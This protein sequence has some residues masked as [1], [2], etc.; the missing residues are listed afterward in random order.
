MNKYSFFFVRLLAK[1]GNHAC[2]KALTSGSGAALIQERTNL[3]LA[4]H[5]E[6]V[7]RA[8]PLV[9]LTRAPALGPA[10]RRRT[11]GPGPG[12]SPHPPS[13]RTGA[14]SCVGAG[15]AD[16]VGCP[17]SA[18]SPRPLG[19]PGP[20]HPTA[21][22]PHTPA[23]PCRRLCRPKIARTLTPTPTPAF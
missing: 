22:S 10:R 11:P 15:S 2:S 16:L 5:G 18:L 14:S 4:P 19:T 3:T 9:H 1:S 13:A 23:R 21:V 6:R 17:A 20:L 7:D 12:A 8:H